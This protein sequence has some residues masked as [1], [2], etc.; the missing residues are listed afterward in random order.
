MLHIRSAPPRSPATSL[1]LND[2]EV[3]PRTLAPGFFAPGDILVS[4]R[5]I[6]TIL[7]LDPAGSKVKFAHSRR[8]SCASTIRI[9]PPATPSPSS[10][11]TTPQGSVL[12]D[13]PR[14][15][16]DPEITAPSG[17][18]REVFGEGP[19][20]FTDIMGE[21]Q[22]LPNGDLLVTATLQGQ[23]LEIAPDGRIAWQFENDLGDGMRGVV[24]EVDLLP[25]EMDAAF[26]EALRAN[27]HGEG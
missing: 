15:E 6:N 18:V 20:Y 4:L 16:P 21:H 19:A 12:S 3:F 22:V 5:D 26:F 24:T 17:A 8:I 27:C 25:P 2:V 11:I 9:S 14:Q 13:G 7:V 1:H 10:T 23:A